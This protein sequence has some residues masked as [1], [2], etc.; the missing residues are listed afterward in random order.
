M[1]KERVFRIPLACVINCIFCPVIP[2]PPFHASLS[3]VILCWRWFCPLG[4]SFGCQD[5]RR[6]SI[7]SLEQG[8]LHVEDTGAQQLVQSC[9]A[10][11][12][13]QGIFPLLYTANTEIQ[14]KK[15]LFFLTSQLICYWLQTTTNISKFIFF[16]WMLHLKY[17]WMP[18]ESSSWSLA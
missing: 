3:S 11:Y 8:R 12:W 17:L 6:K 5:W 4:N 1:F 2:A 16:H 13:L 14:K 9:S 7:I 18:T 15:S 10:T